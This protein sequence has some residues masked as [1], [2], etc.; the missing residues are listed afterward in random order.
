MFPLLSHVQQG[1][2]VADM[3]R[4]QQLQTPPQEQFCSLRRMPGFFSR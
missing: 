4:M 1:G 3:L 2:V